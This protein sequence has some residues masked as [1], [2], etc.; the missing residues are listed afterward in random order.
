MMKPASATTLRRL[1]FAAA[2]LA[3]IIAA[4][5]AL[6]AV[7]RQAEAAELRGYAGDV[8]ASP[9]IELATKTL[10]PF[11]AFAIIA[12]WVR[13]SDLQQDGKFFELN[14]LFRLISQLEPR[15]PNVWSYW[16][17]NVAYN[18][19]VK[20][21]AAQ[22]E[23]R[24]RWVSLGIEI[25]H[26]GIRI[27]PKA[28]MLYR[29]LGWLYS[30]KIGQDMD[31]A[32]IYYKVRLADDMQAALG[33]PP[34]LARLKA[35]A[36][37]PATQAELLRDPAVRSLAEELKAAGAD[38]FARPLEVANRSPQ[39]PSAALDILANP[40]RA[41]AAAGLE[42]FLRA[43]HLRDTLR[44]DAQRM[45]KLMDF[46]P[47]D[48]RLPDAHALYW[49]AISVELFGA[50]VFAVANSDRMLF[51]GLSELY[52]RG[53]LRF[54]PATNEEPASYITAPEFAFL[55]PVI[56][57]HEDIV[58]RHEKSEYQVPT[59]EGF[60]NFLRQAVLDLYSY[61]DLKRAAH[62]LK[63]LVELGGESPQPL[64]QF[65]LNR[66]N[67]LMEAMT[68]TQAMNLVRGMLFR[69]VLWASVGDMDRAVGEENLGRRIYN[70]YREK[71]FSERVK[72]QI[73]PIRELWLDALREAVHTFRDF[74]VD[75][76]RRLYPTDVKAIEEE[77]RKRAEESPERRPSAPGPSP[78][79]R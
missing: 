13:A 46:G 70:Q 79:K 53:H 54:E 75:E 66:Y 12:L 74:Q 68:T 30:H 16:A 45:V 56:R 31:D 1:A 58:K 72:A 59:R 36:A 65:V 15:F 57:L 64:D 23:E 67:K 11:R 51:H 10:G 55:E 37:A 26:N 48:W 8:Q 32:H 27:N 3:C 39:L 2:A 4:S 62:Y 34:Y 40:D 14:D 18:C 9:T 52:R 60:L 78:P 73:P 71:R 28:P 43:G 47:I 22:P 50:D 77:I 7:R 6:T 24:W 21:P 5:Q 41:D 61:N 17:W 33:K 69:S 44:L 38:P 63:R 25:L 76:L 42:A 35:I 49:A 29:E 20:F 19:S